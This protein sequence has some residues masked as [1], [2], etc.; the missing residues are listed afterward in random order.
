MKITKISGGKKKLL[1]LST[2]D[3]KQV[4]KDVF[5]GEN[6]NLLL[7]MIN[8]TFIQACR[9]LAQDSGIDLPGFAEF[10]LQFIDG[11]VRRPVV[12]FIWR[13]KQR[14]LSH[15]M[16]NVLSFELS[17]DDGAYSLLSSSVVGDV[18]EA[19]EAQVVSGVMFS[20]ENGNK[21]IFDRTSAIQ[22]ALDII[23]CVTGY[24]VEPRHDSRILI[25]CEIGK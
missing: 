22:N 14:Q 9:K 3:V 10:S 11:D 19:H 24:Y 21:N 4:F 8:V 6:L 17:M 15:D 18:S 23:D 2:R 25:V 1:Q 7:S 5:P 13:S 20:Y 12:K 16:N